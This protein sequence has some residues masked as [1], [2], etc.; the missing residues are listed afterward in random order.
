MRAGLLEKKA[1]CFTQPSPPVRCQTQLW[2]QPGCCRPP[3]MLQLL[4]SSPKPLVVA[5]LPVAAPA[6]AGN[7]GLPAQA[8]TEQL[9]AGRWAVLLVKELVWVSAGL[10]SANVPGLAGLPVLAMPGAK[11]YFTL[12]PV[13]HVPHVTPEESVYHQWF[14]DVKFDLYTKTRA[15]TTMP[16]C[17]CHTLRTQSKATHTLHP[18]PLPAKVAEFRA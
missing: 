16:R 14:G 7:C 4:H 6:W 17:Q 8:P 18:L 3:F 10:S 2:Q 11:K 1:N 12:V 15:L 13:V 5:T 9:F